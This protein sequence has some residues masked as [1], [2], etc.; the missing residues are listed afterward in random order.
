MGRV[1]A[2]WRRPFA[3]LFLALGSLSL[4]LGSAGCDVDRVEFRPPVEEGTHAVSGAELYYRTI[5]VGEPV[6]V[7]HGGPG[8]E[9]S[10]L[11]PWLEPLGQTYRLIL[12]DQRA[13]GRSTGELDPTS[14]SMDRFIADLDAVRELAGVERMNLLAHSWGGLLAT[15]YALEHPERVR[16][17]ILVSPVEPGQRYARETQERQQARRSPDDDAAIDSL[18]GSEGFARGDRETLSRLFHHVFRGTFADP[19]RADSLRLDFTR[20]TARQGRDVAALLMGPLANLDLWDAL[21]GLTVPVLIVH[22]D[23]DPIPVAMA[24]EMAD[25][26]PDARLEV[27]TDAGHF[28]FIESP[29]PLF[30]AIH[31][32]LEEQQPAAGA[33]D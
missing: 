20:R 12:Y 33:P 24:Q 3:S 11:L 22:G 32:F 14:I 6:V 29:G 8:M 23:R 16:A 15:M 28:P 5:G 2:V 10:Y 31:R 27:L 19:G 26:L 17:L 9:H 18:A 7:V 25:R 4:A 21:A 13:L 30:G 1:E